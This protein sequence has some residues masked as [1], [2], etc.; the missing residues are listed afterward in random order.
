MA[1]PGPRSK[2]ARA[3]DQAVKLHRAALDRLLD[4]RSLPSLQ[5][6]YEGA[7]AELARKLNRLYRAGRQDTMTA[8]QLRQM[9]E[10][11]KL[12]Q[13]DIA[14]ELAAGLRPVAKEAQREGVRQVA[15]TFVDLEK[16]YTGATITV[17]LE[18]AATFAGLVEGR[19]PSLIRSIDTSFAR[20]G[21][22]V[23]Q[24]I[25]KELALSLAT[26]DTQAEAINRIERAANIEWWRAERIVRTELSMSYN[27]GHVASTQLL[28]DEFDDVWNR[29]CEY[30]DDTTGRPLD[31]RVAIDS[32]VLHGQVARPG[33][34]FVMPPDERVPATLWGKTFL[35]G[36]NRPNDRSVT[37]P[38]RPHWGTPAWEWRDGRKVSM[39]LDTRSL[40]E[41]NRE[42]ARLVR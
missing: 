4:K 5:K 34:P 10:Q 35:N 41:L 30:V 33:K 38:W 19:A 42:A 9:L 18:E 40:A 37:M 31:N 32:I 11:V 27:S 8:L 39:Q 1:I 2:S 15:R 3:F 22:T 25:E 20:Y 26:G 29:W 28:G 17:P 23:T 36:P 13:K 21:A 12:A 24:Q 6:F 14:Q 16:H 7:Q